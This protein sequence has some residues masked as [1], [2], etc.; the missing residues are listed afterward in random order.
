VA[1]CRLAWGGREAELRDSPVCEGLA[2]HGRGAIG[3]GEEADLL[4]PRKAEALGGHGENGLV[5]RVQI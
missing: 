3:L 4:R 1:N 5:N 2:G